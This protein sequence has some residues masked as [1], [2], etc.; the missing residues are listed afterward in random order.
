MRGFGNLTVHH[1]RAS[2]DAALLEPVLA[3]TQVSQGR[4]RQGR[5]EP[6]PGPTHQPPNCGRSVTYYPLVHHPSHSAPALTLH[7]TLHQHSLCTASQ[8]AS[9]LSL[10]QHSFFVTA[11]DAPPLIWASPLTLHSV[12]TQAISKFSTTLWSHCFSCLATSCLR[13]GCH[14][15]YVESH[16]DYQNGRRLE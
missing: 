5:L 9:A 11:H 16:A 14:A 1:C 8:S 2:L 6:A 12:L 4:L 13:T 10:H 7:C 3:C 15:M